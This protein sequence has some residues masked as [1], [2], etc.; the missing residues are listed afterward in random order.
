MTRHAAF[1][2]QTD[3]R[4]LELAY[5]TA[6]VASI[7]TRIMPGEDAVLTVT[8]NPGTRPRWEPKEPAADAI[9]D[10]RWLAGH[11]ALTGVAAIIAERRKMIEQPDGEHARYTGDYAAESALDFGEWAI[12]GA[13]AAAVLDEPEQDQT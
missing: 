3:G 1:E 7:G 6:Q 2:A 8:F 12:G 4:W 9:A 11:D 10:L 5:D 13:L